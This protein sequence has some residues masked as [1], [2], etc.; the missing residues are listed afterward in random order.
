MNDQEYKDACE[1]IYGYISDASKDVNGCRFRFDWTH[2]TLIQLDMMAADWSAR[3][4][5]SIAEDRER[6]VEAIAQFE[7][8]VN[9]MMDM[10]AADRD[11]ALRWLR[12]AEM[13]DYF[14][15]DE[16]LEYHYGLPYGYLKGNT[17]RDVINSCL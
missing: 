3:V 10:G 4:F 14:G 11:T 5:E 15:D 13:D 17:M 8:H 16:H 7:Q 9:G 12:D 1:D 2:Y 6:E